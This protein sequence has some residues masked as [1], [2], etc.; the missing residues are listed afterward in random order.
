MALVRCVPWKPRFLNMFNSNDDS[1]HE[2]EPI[3][4]EI[5]RLDQEVYRAVTS[6]YVLRTVHREMDQDPTT[7]AV[8]NSSSWMWQPILFSLQ[9]TFFIQI[10]RVFDGTSQHSIDKVVDAT[11]EDAS[12]HNPENATSLC[13]LREQVAL[14]TE[15][16]TP[17]RNIRSKVYAHPALRD[18]N[19]IEELFSETEIGDVEDILLFL[20]R[21]VSSLRM[22]I[23]NGYD[24]NLSEQKLPLTDNVIEDTKR[25]LEKLRCPTK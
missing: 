3:Q 9:C 19:K 11:I 20:Q 14:Y 1:E 23:L 16:S 13:Q 2:M 17:Y 5:E 8:I 4:T 24:V 21:C 7:H 15:R 6:Y 25:F 18:M 10:S 22:Y 12:Q